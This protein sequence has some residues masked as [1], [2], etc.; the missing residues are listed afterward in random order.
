LS[1]FENDIKEFQLTIKDLSH[2]LV[3]LEENNLS[4]LIR[5]LELKNEL[6]QISLNTF[7][8]DFMLNL[9]KEKEKFNKNTLNQLQNMNSEYNNR[10]KEVKEKFYRKEELLKSKYYVNINS[11]SH[12]IGNGKENQEKDEKINFLER[13]LKELTYINECLEKENR[14]FSF[15]T[16]FLE[17]NVKNVE[18]NERLH[19]YNNF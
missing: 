15:S 19:N 18:H 6:N 3:I 5:Y 17:Q 9:L 2:K 7:K 8:N 16:R 10:L 1:K 14:Q 13:K 12:S 11:D 4:K